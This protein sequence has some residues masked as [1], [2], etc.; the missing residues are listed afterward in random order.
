[1][2]IGVIY[3]N[4]LDEDF[5][6]LSALERVLLNRE[7]TPI[8]LL[9]KNTG[10]H[11]EKLVLILR[12]LHGLKLVKKETIMGEKCFRLTFLGYDMLAIKAL[13]RANIIEAIGDKIG[14]GKESD[15]Y[16]GLAPGGLQVAV[17]FLRIGRTSF[18]QTKRVR[19]WTRGKIAD[20][21]QQSKICAEREF[22][23]L[24]ALHKVGALVPKPMGFNRHVVVIEFIDGL[25]LYERP[26]LENPLGVLSKIL[27]TISIAYHK[28]Q[29]VHG[30]L[31]EYNILVRREDETP[32]IIDWPQYVY[33]DDP[34]APELLKRDVFYVVRFF[35]RVY[36]LS[37]NPQESLNSVLN[38]KETF[39][40]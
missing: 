9:E 39:N 36:R 19:V 5:K 6:V 18:R 29:I 3:K 8:Q 38:W 12:K 21:Y 4:L 33:R 16:I 40:Y 30:D 27:E 37:V 26:N 1:L 35:N 34:S 25:E 31:S 2:N 20:W 32:F 7:Y 10:I 22:K 15:I 14:V 24:Q 23:A 11:E 17:K 28:A 13:A